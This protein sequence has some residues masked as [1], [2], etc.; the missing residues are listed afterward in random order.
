MA[1]TKELVIIGGPNGSGKT[2][3]TQ[4]YIELHPMACLNADEIAKTIDPVNMSRVSV[5]AGKI[6][7]K[8]LEE[9]KKRGESVLIESTLS[10]TYLTKMMNDFHKEGYEVTLVY[11]FLYSPEVCIERIKERVLKGGHFVPNRDVI[12]RYY[13]SK[14][15]FWNNYKNEAD[16]WFLVYNSE[17]KFIPIALG[18]KNQFSIE[19]KDYFYKFMSKF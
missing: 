10:G 9:Y 19:N 1:D 14:E 17:N 16:K 15:N 11:V 7:F 8:Q 3:F 4:S 13:R 2:T 6:F 12:R 18:M 5:S